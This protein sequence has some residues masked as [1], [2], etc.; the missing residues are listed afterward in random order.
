MYD[1]RIDYK[2]VIEQVSGVNCYPVVVPDGAEYP[3]TM[4]TIS[5]G[6]RDADSSNTQSELSNIRLSITVMAS[7]LT[8]VSQI[9]QKIMDGLKN[10][11]LVTENTKTLIMYFDGIVDIY[12]TQLS[13]F[14]TT[15]D[16]QTRKL[17]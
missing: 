12:N 2:S 6:K 10:K 8:E 11:S 17:N 13:L 14:E 15:V 1:L 9:A 7:T 4:M 5:G 3:C 16:F